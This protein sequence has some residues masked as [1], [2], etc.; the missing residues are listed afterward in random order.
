MFDV[1]HPPS[2]K[3]GQMRTITVFCSF[4][5]KYRISRKNCVAGKYLDL[6]CD[7]KGNNKK[8]NFSGPRFVFSSGKSYAGGNKIR[9]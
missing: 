8:K 3:N 9:R 2:L 6:I 1:T 4:L 5:R 7:K